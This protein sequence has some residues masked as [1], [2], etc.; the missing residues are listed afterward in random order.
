MEGSMHTVAS[1]MFTTTSSPWARLGRGGLHD[2]GSRSSY[3]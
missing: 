1:D 3:M 2:H